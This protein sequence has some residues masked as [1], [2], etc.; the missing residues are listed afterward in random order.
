MSYWLYT[1]E[2]TTPQFITKTKKEPFDWLDRH[3][4]ESIVATSPKIITTVLLML[5]TQSPCSCVVVLITV[6]NPILFDSK[7]TSWM[8]LMSVIKTLTICIKFSHSSDLFK[9][10]NFCQI[11]MPIRTRQNFI[12]DE[13]EEKN[14]KKKLPALIFKPKILDFITSFQPWWGALGWS[15]LCRFQ[16]G[17]FKWLNKIGTMFDWV[18]I[19][20]LPKA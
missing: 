18:W 12:N 2:A 17:R 11:L 14:Q 20:Y 10:L 4:H 6:S 16:N 15:N 5:A 3:S 19:Q 9:M 8:K 7:W 1:S 13:E